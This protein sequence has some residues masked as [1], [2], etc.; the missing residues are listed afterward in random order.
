MKKLFALLLAFSCLFLTAC[1]QKPAD[2]TTGTGNP[3]N[4]VQPNELEVKDTIVY[5]LNEGFIDLPSRIIYQHQ[6]NKINI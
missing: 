1:N 2:S 3:Q 4:Q 5:N 6:Y